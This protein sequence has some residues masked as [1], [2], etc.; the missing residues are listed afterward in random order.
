[1]KTT[2]TAKEAAQLLEIS[3]KAFQVKANQ[4]DS[5]LERSG[6]SGRY[7]SASVIREYERIHRKPYETAVEELI[8]S[9]TSAED[10]KLAKQYRIPSYLKL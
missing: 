1:M 9:M 7:F 8:N 5:K 3:G 2:L 10:K 4:Q 6:M